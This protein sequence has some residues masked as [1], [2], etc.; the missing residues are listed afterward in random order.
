MIVA[1][2]SSA[3]VVVTSVLPPVI[4]PPPGAY[5]SVNVPVVSM[6]L[7][8]ESSSL[9]VRLVAWSALPSCRLSCCRNE[10]K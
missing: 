8:S 9:T 4:Q 10:L 6:P 2:L 7:L 1:V 3:G 5:V